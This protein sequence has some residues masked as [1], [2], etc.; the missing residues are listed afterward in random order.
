MVKGLNALYIYIY[1]KI[2]FSAEKTYIDRW[3]TFGLPI[4]KE[5]YSRAK[6]SVS[7]P[8]GGNQKNRL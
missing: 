8:L 5:D 6:I 7:G 3:Y 4:L 1:Y 2:N